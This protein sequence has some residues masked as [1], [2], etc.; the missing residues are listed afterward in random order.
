[1]NQLVFIGVDDTD[2]LGGAFG[3]GRV[4]KRM[5]ANA[6][7]LGLG[8]TKAVIRLQLLVDPRIKYTSHNSAKCI[9]FEAFS[10]LPEL[11]EVCIKFLNENF[12]Q[13][14][15]DPGICTCGQ[16]QVTEEL[17]EY[18]KSAKTDYI[19]KDQAISLARKT[20]ILLTEVGG[21]GDGVIGALAAVGLRGWGNDGRYNL[22]RG[23]KEIKGMATVNSLLSQTGITSVIDEHGNPVGGDEIIDTH[24]WVK[25]NVVNG[26][27][28]LRIRL[29][30]KNSGSRI[31]ETIEQK[32]KKDKKKE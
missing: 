17:I 22:L 11:H 7:D 18:G 29:S 2:I 15:A 5:A 10:T 25:P 13:E 28:T 31:W 26:Q 19:I 14:G 6:V 9:E 4:A 20:G 23:I 8:R 16:E 30:D 3:T 21:S 27:P 24:D 32:I 12:H 1:M